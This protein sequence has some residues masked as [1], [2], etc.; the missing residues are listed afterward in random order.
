MPATTQYMSGTSAGHRNVWL[1]TC[2]NHIDCDLLLDTV[3][4][5]KL[6]SISPK[7]YFLNALDR[8]QSVDYHLRPVLFISK[9]LKRKRLHFNKARELSPSTDVATGC[10]SH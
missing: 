2:I 6:V 10:A 5:A 7:H 4:L 1:Y 8:R 9:E 3:V